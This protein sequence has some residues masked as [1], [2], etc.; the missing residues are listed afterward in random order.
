[1]LH[2]TT[3][4]EP[5]PVG[6]PAGG[7]PLWR[8]MATQTLAL[9]LVTLATPAAHGVEASLAQGVIAAL[10]GAPGL[11]KPVIEG[12]VTDIAFYAFWLGFWL[13]MPVPIL[14]GTLAWALYDLCTLRGYRQPCGPILVTGCEGGFG[15][16][17]VRALAEKGWQVNALLD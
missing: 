11:G 6:R 7:A 17:L 15:R 12:Y 13:L 16:D 2:A 1:M 3:H 8:A 10:I 4:T 14:W 9:L 5:A